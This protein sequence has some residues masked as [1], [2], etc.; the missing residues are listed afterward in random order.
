MSQESDRWWCE[1]CGEEVRPTCD[2]RCGRHQ[3]PVPDLGDPEEEGDVYP[4]RGCAV[5]PAEEDQ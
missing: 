3:R 4:R 5:T 2:C 1:N